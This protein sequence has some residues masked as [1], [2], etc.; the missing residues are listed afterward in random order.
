MLPYERALTSRRSS[1]IDK[2]GWQAQKTH[3]TPY[4]AEPQ[5][6]N[7]EIISVISSKHAHTVAQGTTAETFVC[8]YYLR[9]RQNSKN[10][11]SQRALYFIQ[12]TVIVNEWITK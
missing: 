11:Y 8:R 12:G 9:Q 2:I 3:V 6:H 7:S 10:V 4:G 5:A 1:T